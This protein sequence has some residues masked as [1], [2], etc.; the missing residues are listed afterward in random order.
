LYRADLAVYVRKQIFDSL[1][2]V[3]LDLRS[4]IIDHAEDRETRE[5]DERQRSHDC[6]HREPCLNAKAAAP[7]E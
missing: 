1:L 4:L 5:R 6:Q 2:D 7:H 3:Q